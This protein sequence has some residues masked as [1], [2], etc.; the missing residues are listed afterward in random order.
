MGRYDCNSKMMEPGNYIV[1]VSSYPQE[2]TVGGGFIKIEIEFTIEGMDK[3]LKQGYFPNQLKTLFEALG[4]KELEPGI[5]DGD[6]QEAYGKTY[7]AEL[8]LEE[9]KK[10]DGST[11]KARRL[12]NFKAVDDCPPEVAGPEQIAWEE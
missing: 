10:A 2:V 6:I 9:Y 11:G 4:W 3:P 1:K 5:Y 12:R 8:Y 7:L